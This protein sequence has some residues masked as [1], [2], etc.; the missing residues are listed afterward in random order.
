MRLIDADRLL[1]PKRI[2][3]YYHLPN[4]DIAIPIIDI[5][6]ATS[7]ETIYGY[8]FNELAFVASLLAKEGVSPTELI[9]IIWDAERIAEI[10]CK[11][12]K[13]NFH[14]AMKGFM[15]DE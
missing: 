5:E 11:E 3:K 9:R 6:H 1:E 2:G 14:K 12:I 10:I 13:D 8:H 15:E 7:I 4:G